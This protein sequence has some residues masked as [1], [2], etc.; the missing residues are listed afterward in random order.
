MRPNCHFMLIALFAFLLSVPTTKIF[1]A[2]AEPVF[3]PQGAI[4]CSTFEH[5][6]ALGAWVTSKKKVP[7]RVKPSKS[8]K[9]LGYLPPLVGE[10]TTRFDILETRP[11]W[12]KI[13]RADKRSAPYK[14]DKWEKWS[15]YNGD[16]WIPATTA[17]VGVQSA[18]G[19]AK[20][21]V[22]S[23]RIIDLG[24]DW[25]TDNANVTIRACSG[26]WLLLDYTF[27]EKKQHGTAWFR[28]ICQ[29]QETTCD[30]ESVDDKP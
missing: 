18:R 29:I 4:D 20:P 2:S 15:L 24:S 17:G 12:L 26:N 22:N 27:H 16:G 13:T 1:A 5:N 6:E 7:I 19:Y 28:G 14:D 25:L 3:I 8:A 10:Y 9:I 21:D 30:M 11:G 23:F